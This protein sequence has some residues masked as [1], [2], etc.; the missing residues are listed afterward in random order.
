[1]A[2]EAARIAIKYMTPVIFLSDGYLANGTEPFRIPEIADL[3]E[4]PVAFREARNGTPFLPYERNA[5]TLARPW[6]I[7]G[8]PGLEHRLGGL[9]KTDGTGNVSYDPINHEH[10]IHTRAAKVERVVAEIPPTEVFGARKGKV[11]V[12]GWGGTYGA[13]HG[14][15]RRAVDAGLP[16]GQI[17]LRHL[18]PLPPDLGE[19][20]GRYDRVLAPELNTGQLRMLLRARFLVDVIGLNKVQGRPFSVEEILTRIEE[21]VE[22]AS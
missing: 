14:A 2:F 9:E 5:E 11:L 21:L 10:M 8:T 19:I 3:P 1:M 12:V 13:I 17:H 20:L 7:P 16:V 15:V 4:I 6:A 18:N 22:A